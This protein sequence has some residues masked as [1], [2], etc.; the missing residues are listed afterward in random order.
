MIIHAT[1]NIFFIIYDLVLEKLYGT[2]L[3]ILTIKSL[4]VNYHLSMLTFFSIVF[5]TSIEL[6]FLTFRIASLKWWS[7]FT[8]NWLNNTL[9]H[10]ASSSLCSLDTLKINERKFK[11]L[12]WLNRNFMY[13]LYKKNQSTECQPM[14]VCQGLSIYLKF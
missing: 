9:A 10:F 7:S 1:V 13:T 5:T 11:P 8:L 14:L 3:H 4:F 12:P 2:T 6:D